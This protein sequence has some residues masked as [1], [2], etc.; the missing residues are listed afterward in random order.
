VSALVVCHDGERELLDTLTAAWADTLRAGLFGSP[1]TPTPADDISTYQ[2]IESTFPGYVR[3]PLL[4]WQPA[5][6]VASGN[7]RSL[8]DIVIFTRSTSGVGA[9]VYGYF[10]VSGGGGLLW[11]QV[12]PHAPVVLAVGGAVYSFFPAVET[13]QLVL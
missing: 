6:I 12:D 1:H 7:A 11:A 8:A 4:N 13:G 9:P 10:V 3:Q 5:V 2:A